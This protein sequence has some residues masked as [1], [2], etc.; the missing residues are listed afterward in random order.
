[1]RAQLLARQLLGSRQATLLDRR[2]FL[3]VSTR[4]A[5]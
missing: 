2:R 3:R 4:Q 5:A 1:M